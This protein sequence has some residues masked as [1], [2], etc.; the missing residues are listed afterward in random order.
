MDALASGTVSVQLALALP[1]QQWVKS[2]NVAQ[3]TTVQ[4]VIDHSG[5]AEAF[6]QLDFAALGTGVW[7]EAAP[8]ERLVEPGD[9]VELYRPLILDPRE[10]RR[11]L[12]AAGQTMG[13]ELPAPSD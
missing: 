4:D 9:R 13:A 1:D 7:G 11:A 5:V 2:L 10:A 8:R 6:P 3:G 12:A